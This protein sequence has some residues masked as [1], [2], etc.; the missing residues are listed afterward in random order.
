M[1]IA[2]IFICSMDSVRPDL[3]Y[4]QN[5]QCDFFKWKPVYRY[6]QNMNA[7]SQKF[8]R[9]RTQKKSVRKREK[10]VYTFFYVQ[11]D[12]HTKFVLN[13]EHKCVIILGCCCADYYYRI[14][15]VWK[16]APKQVVFFLISLDFNENRVRINMQIF[17]SH[18][19]FNESFHFLF[20][21]QQK[22]IAINCRHE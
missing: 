17:L 4:A 11:S 22:N 2:H 1:Y 20:A 13:Y 18:F 19:S 9:K 15:K 3:L 16:C 14:I 12:L 5:M 8:Y 10:C 21:V 7:Q 6:T